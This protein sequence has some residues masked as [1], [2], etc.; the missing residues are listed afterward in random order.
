MPGREEAQQQ[1]D[2]P[3]VLSFYSD[4]PG[5]PFRE[6]SNFFRDAP[7]FQFV[8][9]DFARRDGWP[10]EVLCECSEKAI[11]LCKAATMNDAE[12][13]KEISETADPAAVKSLGRLVQNWNQELWDQHISSV[14]F[15]AVRQK[16]Q[17]NRALREVL[18]STGDVIIAE[19]APRDAIWG[20]GLALGDERCKDPKLW[21]GRNELGKA[22]MRAR[23]VLRGDP[24]P[25]RE[26]GVGPGEA[27]RVPEPVDLDAMRQSADDDDS[28]AST[29]KAERRWQRSR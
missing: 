19:A 26:L 6:F 2:R 4:K 28:A 25:A 24:D 8:L 10:T 5:N 23:A 15:E 27:G 29:G 21:R 11:M 16:F 1:G 3:R 17:A 7:P 9:P 12:S 18:L 14:A 22:L 13:F 20:I